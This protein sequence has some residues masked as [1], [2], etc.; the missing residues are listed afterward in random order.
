MKDLCK[1]N[2]IPTADYARF[3]NKE[4]AINY[5]NAQSLPIVIKA[6][7]LA[8]GKGVTVAD[9]KKMAEQAI[10]DIFDE[11]FGQIWM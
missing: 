9:T 8:A 10:N 3:D 4:E 7:G 6:D 11:K 5:L 2:R 1:Q